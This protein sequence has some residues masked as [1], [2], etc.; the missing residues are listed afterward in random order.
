MEIAEL[1]AS[2]HRPLVVAPGGE[3]VRIVRRRRRRTSRPRRA[4]SGRGTASPARPAPRARP[5][6]SVERRRRPKTTSRPDPWNASFVA[7]ATAHASRECASV[8]SWVTRK[9]PVSATVATR[10]PPSPRRPPRAANPRASSN[11]SPTPRTSPCRAPRGAPGASTSF[12]TAWRA[13]VGSRAR[14]RGKASGTG[15]VA[16]LRHVVVRP[17]SSPARARARRGGG[18]PAAAREE[19]GEP[20]EREEGVIIDD[21]GGGGVADRIGRAARRA[22]AACPRPPAGAGKTPRRRAPCAH[23]SGQHS[24]PR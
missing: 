12:S 4:S 22:T 10:K 18:S 7:N 19:N 13:S 2:R 3:R 11:R 20:V 16:W 5:R 21:G 24:L 17:A 15:G 9:S 1:A 6:L 23:R 14:G 8:A